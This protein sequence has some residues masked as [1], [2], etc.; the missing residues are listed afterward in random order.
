MAVGER[1]GVQCLVWCRQPQPEL[2]EILGAW[3]KRRATSF[4][5]GGKAPVPFDV[6][7]HQVKIEL[8]T[9]HFLQ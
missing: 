1:G 4:L 3:G 7:V 8:M 5:R 2:V 9:S 6:L